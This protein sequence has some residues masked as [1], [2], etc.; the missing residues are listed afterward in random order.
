VDFGEGVPPAARTTV[1]WVAGNIR[2]PSC[3]VVLLPIS[4]QYGK[5]AQGN[6]VAPITCPRAL[7][8]TAAPVGLIDVPRLPSP[9]PGVCRKPLLPS[10]RIL[11]A[12]FDLHPPGATAPTGASLSVPQAAPWCARESTQSSPAR[13]SVAD[14][15]PLILLWRW[16]SRGSKTCP[17]VGSGPPADRKH[18]R[19]SAAVVQIGPKALRTPAVML[20]SGWRHLRGRRQCC[21]RI[22]R[23]YNK[24]SNQ[25]RLGET[26]RAEFDGG[27]DA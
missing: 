14:S 18:H 25:R 22:G 21:E 8:A 27:L 19:T 3:D 7:T 5:P 16:S 20:R 24:A 1:H 11:V 2:K 9:T 4:S 13:R 23:A 17:P 6:T 15:A 10:S 12:A 26:Q